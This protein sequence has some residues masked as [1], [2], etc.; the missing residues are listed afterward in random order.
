MIPIGEV[1][2]ST[3]PMQMN[4]LVHTSHFAA[5]SGMLCVV[6]LHHVGPTTV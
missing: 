5:P 4:D 3:S 6:V 1:P 2:F